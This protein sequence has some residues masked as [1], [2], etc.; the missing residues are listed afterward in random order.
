[1][2]C[3]YAGQFAR[4]CVDKLRNQVTENIL[5]MFGNAKGSKVSEKMD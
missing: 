1:M 2:D 3:W 4:Y 5:S